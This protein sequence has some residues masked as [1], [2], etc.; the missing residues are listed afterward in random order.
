[1]GTLNVVI[2]INLVHTWFKDNVVNATSSTVPGD[3]EPSS[4]NQV[5]AGNVI[6]NFYH[7]KP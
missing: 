3:L 1:M 6:L 4:S 5:R 2:G 7:I